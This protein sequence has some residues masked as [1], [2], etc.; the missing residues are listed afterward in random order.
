MVTD[1]AEER[2]RPR[3]WPG[4]DDGEASA[5]KPAG[6]P[7]PGTAVGEAIS[8]SWLGDFD[9][10]GGDA[11]AVHSPPPTAD[12]P[13]SPP[14]SKP[15]HIPAARENIGVVALADRRNRPPKAPAPPRFVR[16][17]PRGPAVG[18]TALL[19]FGLLSAF[20]AWVTA[21]PFW[22]A[23]RHAEPGTA[24]VTAC[25]GSGLSRRCTGEFASAD[26][27]F[28]RS[29]IPIMGAAPDPGGAAPARMTSSRAARA[30]LGTGASPRAG[31]GIGL[32]VLCGLLIAWS[33][34]TLRLPSGRTR[35]LAFTGCLVAPLLLF[36]G[37]LAA[38]F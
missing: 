10:T 24:T 4:Q 19:L 3:P 9:S 1:S 21:E 25:S 35:F 8:P 29:G 27:G 28:R 2:P 7:R 18:F 14:Q 33:T 31:L 26:G 32:L 22:L 20:F 38:T 30:Y 5:G 13:A 34:G 16:K 15:T 17:A 6:G 36:G 23:V 37:M 11:P 12:E